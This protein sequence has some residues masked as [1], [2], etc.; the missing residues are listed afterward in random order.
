MQLWVAGTNYL[1]RRK[2]DIDDNSKQIGMELLHPQDYSKVTRPLSQ[3]LFNNLFARSVIEHK[4]TGKVFVDNPDDPKTF[5]VVHPYGM[6]LL[7][8]DSK[9]AD[10]NRKFLDYS[11]NVNKTR[12]KHEWLQAYPSQWD[13]VL[14]DL[15]SDIL[16]ASQNN[17]D[18]VDS[19]IIEL[20]TRVHFKFNPQKYLQNKNKALPKDCEIVRTDQKLFHEMP[21]AVIPNNFWNTFE[22]FSKIG[23]GYTVLCNQQIASTAFSAFVIDEMLEIG[24]ESLSQFRGNGLAQIAC[25]ALIDYCLDQKLEPVWACR[26]EN[27]N[28]LFLAEKLG[29]E[30]CNKVPYY[31]LGI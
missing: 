25:S 19:G 4:I 1:F 20:N 11:L 27:K 10:F 26:L 2:Q 13:E 5:Y 31:K 6:S 3:V 30:I 15:F 16:V 8:G 17:S 14:A 29:F 18:G 28:S 24:I 23:A 21:G 7:F 12:D 9:N 22:D